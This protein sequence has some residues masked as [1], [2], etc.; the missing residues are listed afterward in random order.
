MYLDFFVRHVV[1]VFINSARLGTP[2]RG[3]KS[4]KYNSKMV[5]KEQGK[6]GLVVTGASCNRRSVWHS[7]PGDHLQ[8]N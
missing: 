7:K 6:A 5:N 2:P 3:V 4:Y 8:K 1:V